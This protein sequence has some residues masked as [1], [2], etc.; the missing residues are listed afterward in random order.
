MNVVSVMAHQDDEMRCMGTMLKCL[1]RGDTLA[2]ITLTDGG[3]GV[4]QI[5]PVSTREAAEI[6]RREMQ[7]IA[8]LLGAEYISLQE[9]D[10]FLYDTPEVRTRLIEALRRTRAELVFTHFSEDYNLD[11]TTTCSLVRH[12]A[13]NASLPVV[14][15][16]SAPLVRHPAIFMVEPHGPIAFTPTH[17]V[18]ISAYEDRK[19]EI[20]KRHISQEDAMIKALGTGFDDLARRPDSFWGN[21]VGCAYAECFRPM[22]ARGANK[23]FPVLP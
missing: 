21:N 16:A 3:Q 6:R 8:D 4:F 10:E 12:C 15:T 7:S 2:F 11:H 18:D 14:P 1:D 19:I 5:P 13:M 17:F 22:E 23:P 20:L 9:P